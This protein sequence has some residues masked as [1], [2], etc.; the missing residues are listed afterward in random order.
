[1][2]IEGLSAPAP[3]GLKGVGGGLL[4]RLEREAL[5]EE[6][7]REAADRPASKGTPYRHNVAVGFAYD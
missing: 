7:A 2:E 5:A 6:A 3:V 4:E 1:M